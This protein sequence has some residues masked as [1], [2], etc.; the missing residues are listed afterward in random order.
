MVNMSGSDSAGSS[1]RGRTNAIN[2]VAL[3]ASVS[4]GDGVVVG[5]GVGDGVVE[6]VAVTRTIVTGGSA[7]TEGSCVA[8][9]VSG[10]DVGAS[11][12]VGNAV[13]WN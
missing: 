5:V 1:V 6:G 4:I 3:A 9:A 13:S 2:G 8:V 11:V 10:W 12:R 7:V